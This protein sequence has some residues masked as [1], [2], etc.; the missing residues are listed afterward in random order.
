[1]GPGAGVRALVRAAYR[2]VRFPFHLVD[3]VV[4]P[5][6]FDEDAPVR[7][8]YGKFLLDCD[9]SNVHAAVD[10]EGRVSELHGA[11][12]PN[13]VDPTTASGGA[14]QPPSIAVPTRAFAQSIQGDC[15]PRHGRE[16]WAPRWSVGRARE[17]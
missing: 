6:I 8:A 16:Q 12:G 10:Q 3:D 2:L 17:P 1:M 13:S 7:R 9:G 15:A 5:V 4:L 11:G 14:R